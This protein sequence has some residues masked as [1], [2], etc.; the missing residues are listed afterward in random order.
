[1]ETMQTLAN[2]FFS[3]CVCVCLRNKQ[4]IGMNESKLT[5]GYATEIGA[6]R[7][8]I[9]CRAVD[10]GGGLQDD[11]CNRCCAMDNVIGW[12]RPMMT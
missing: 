4:G 1:M 3:L 9:W 6:V 5:T 2:Q 12:Y 10:D 11:P 8:A 7:L